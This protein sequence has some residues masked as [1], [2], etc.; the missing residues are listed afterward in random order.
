MTRLEEDLGWP[1][2]GATA[3]MG[4]CSS[5]ILADS[6]VRNNV[7]GIDEHCYNYAVIEEVEEGIYPLRINRWFYQ[8]NREE[9]IFESIPE[10][11]FMN[12]IAGVL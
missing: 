7:G 10:P 6:A 12:H 2:F 8:Y 5:F 11:N 3:F 1:N 4:Y 9:D